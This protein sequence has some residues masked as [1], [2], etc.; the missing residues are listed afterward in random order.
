MLS[1]LDKLESEIAN[2]ISR[3]DDPDRI[4][5]DITQYNVPSEF[6]SIYDRLVARRDAR[7][8]LARRAETADEGAKEDVPEVR[9]PAK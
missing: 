5:R 9:P 2:G 4:R 3:G 8:E 6:W 7:A 1:R